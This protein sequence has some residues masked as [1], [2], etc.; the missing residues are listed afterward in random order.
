VGITMLRVPNREVW[1]RS[2]LVRSGRFRGPLT[3]SS[4]RGILLH[5]RFQ[6]P[7]V[8]EGSPPCQGR[9]GNRTDCLVASS[10]PLASA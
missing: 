1:E 6:P 3:K 5:G 7:E 4:P 2:G 10:S 9:T 8:L